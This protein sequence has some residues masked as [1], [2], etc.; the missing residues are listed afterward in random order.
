MVIRKRTI[1]ALAPSFLSLSLFSVF[2]II[3]MWD[4]SRA[5]HHQSDSQLSYRCTEQFFFFLSREREVG[6]RFVIEKRWTNA[7]VFLS[8]FQFKTKI[9]VCVYI[10]SFI[11]FFFFSVLLTGR[12]VIWFVFVRLSTFIFFSLSRSLF[13]ITGGTAYHVLFID[14]RN[15]SLC[16]WLIAS[17]AEAVS[18][19]ITKKKRWMIKRSIYICVCVSLVWTIEYARILMNTGPEVREIGISE[20]QGKIELKNSIGNRFVQFQ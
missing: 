18:E 10:C 3:S 5:I 6:K 19:L 11:F 16:R 17:R 14:A 7:F 12:F 1:C 8:V 2:I 13:L 9:S 15:F 4:S 20:R